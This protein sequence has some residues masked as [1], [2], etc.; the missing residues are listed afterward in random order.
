MSYRLY[1]DTS[2]FGALFDEED[3][4]RVKL[5]T[6]VLRRIKHAPFEAFIGTPVLEEISIAPLRLRVTLER[7]LKSLS[8]TLIEEGPASLRLAERRTW[9][10][11]LS[12]PRS[13]TTPDTLP[14]QR[15]AILTRLSPGTSVIWST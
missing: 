4:E 9:P 13:G 6:V 8:P 2:V 15:S 7:Q 12:L 11:G 3:H 1:V 10:P 5:T 14:L